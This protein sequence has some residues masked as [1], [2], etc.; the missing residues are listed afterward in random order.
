MEL[1]LRK[2]V[3]P[4]NIFHFHTQAT[5]KN[6]SFSSTRQKFAK[7][8]FN[9]PNT[10]YTQY[11]YSR[12]YADLTVI[13]RRY[14]ATNCTALVNLKICCIMLVCYCVCLPTMMQSKSYGSCTPQGRL[15]LWSRFF[16][17][18]RIPLHHVVVTRRKHKHR[19][20]YESIFHIRFNVSSFL[21]FVKTNDEYTLNP[22]RYEYYA[23][24]SCTNFFIKES[25][26]K[27]KKMNE[28]VLRAH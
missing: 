5:K 20:G 15:E 1:F 18:N 6:Y 25:T 28:I 21:E 24:K 11:P 14:H 16:L 2:H 7:N 19:I 8:P 3:Q 22:F 13:L 23:Y 12:I 17:Q 4:L 10:T 26:E 27:K 9:S